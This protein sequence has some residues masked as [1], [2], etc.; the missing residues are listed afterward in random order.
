MTSKLVSL[1]VVHAEDTANFFYRPLEMFFFHMYT[2]DDPTS[3]D[4]LLLNWLS[5]LVSAKD[6]NGTDEGR[7]WKSKKKNH[8]PAY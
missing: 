8:L 4:S 2:T 1:P 5:S 3:K 7:Q 6:K